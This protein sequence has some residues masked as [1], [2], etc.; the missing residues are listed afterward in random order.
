MKQKVRGW[1]SAL[2]D[3]YDF[4][5]VWFFDLTKYCITTTFLEDKWNF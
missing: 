1:F 2:H 4:I 5:I 3:I